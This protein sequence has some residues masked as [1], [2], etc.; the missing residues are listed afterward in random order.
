MTLFN[1]VSPE[2][3]KCIW[4]WSA[5]NRSSTNSAPRDIFW[6]TLIRAILKQLP[7]VAGN[8]CAKS[9]ESKGKDWS[10][11]GEPF[12]TRQS[13]DKRR[14]PGH[15]DSVRGALSHRPPLWRGLATAGLQPSR[16]ERSVLWSPLPWWEVPAVHRDSENLEH[17]QT[18]LGVCWECAHVSEGQHLWKQRSGS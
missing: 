7:G 14:G 13:P 2:P 1:F 17:L 12:C 11:C 10:T 18:K 3:F 15:R 5:E 9:L 4:L 8:I 6:E 16:W